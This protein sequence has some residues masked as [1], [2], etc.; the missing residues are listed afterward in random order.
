MIFFPAECTSFI[1]I[2][3]FATPKPKSEKPVA[4]K[5]QKSGEMISSSSSGNIFGRRNAPGEVKLKLKSNDKL[6][7]KE[8]SEESAD[9]DQSDVESKESSSE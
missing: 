9:H 7:S 8:R 2:L 4:A 1:Q 3:A 6:G 5:K